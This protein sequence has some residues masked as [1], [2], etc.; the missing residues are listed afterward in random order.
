MYFEFFADTTK[1]E[2][3]SFYRS[4]AAAGGDNATTSIGL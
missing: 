3:V 4:F 1:S 2:A